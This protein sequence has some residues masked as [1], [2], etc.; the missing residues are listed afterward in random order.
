METNTLGRF[1]Y[2]HRK[3]KKK[4]KEKLLVGSVKT[5]IGHTESAAGVAGLIKVLLMMKHGKIVPSLHIKKDKSNLNPAIKLDV[6]GMDIPVDV[7]DWI[8]NEHGDRT[9]CVNSFGFGGSNGH[10]I[11]IQKKSRNACA[12]ETELRDNSSSE[13]FVTV[14]AA[15]PED[16][17]HALETFSAQLE[18]AEDSLESISYTSTCRRDHFPYRACF[19][20]ASL[21]SLATQISQRITQNKRPTVPTNI[22]FVYCGVGTTW[23]GMCS[24]LIAVDEAFRKGVQEVDKYLQPLA[25]MSMTKLFSDSTTD[26]SDPFLNHLAIFSTQVGLTEMWRN[27]RVEPGVIVGQS[28]GEVAAAYASG[29]FDLKTAVE[30]IYHRSKILANQIGGMM[31]VVKN[32]DVQ[33]LEKLCDSYDR[34]VTIAVYSSPV[35]CTLSG[36]RDVMD[37]I[38]CDVVKYCKE[39]KIDEF[40]RDL[41]VQCAYHC[42]MM[43]ACLPDIRQKL[44]SLRAAPRTFEIVSTVT[45][46]QAVSNEYQTG[47]YWAR[48]VRD[49]V[50]LNEAILASSKS[51][52]KNIFIEIGPK[53]ILRAHINDIL[54]Q[55]P[56]VCLPSM[57]YQ[58][59]IISR[60]STVIE[61]FE[62]GVNIEWNKEVQSSSL[63]NIPSY[64]FARR[65]ILFIPE[66]EKRKFQGLESTQ[67]TDHMF[68]RNSLKEGK[69]F[70]LTIGRNSTNFVYDH[71]MGGSL[72]VPGATYVEAALAIACRKLKLSVVKVAVSI[73]FLHTHTPTEEKE[74]EI[75]CGL[76]LHETSIDI[77]FTKGNRLLS[78]GRAFKSEPFHKKPLKIPKLIDIFSKENT[79][80]DVYAALERLGFKYGPSLCLIQRAWFS[81]TECLAEM[82]VPSSI[83]Q[84]FGKTHVHPAVIDA[85]FQVFGIFAQKTNTNGDP[86][87]PKGLHSLRV[88]GHL[89]P[90]LYCYT[91]K[92]RSVGKQTYYNAMLLDTDGCVICEVKDFYTQQL[93]SEP[94]SQSMC[95]SL[96]WIRLANDDVNTNSL[97]TSK[98]HLIVFATKEAKRFLQHALKEATINYVPLNLAKHFERLN[99]HQLLQLTEQ[100]TYD[101]VL[102]VPFTN[103]ALTQDTS[104]LLYVI[105]SRTILCLKDLILSLSRTSTQVPL[106]ILTNNT[107]MLSEQANTSPNLCGSELW[108]MVRCAALESLHPDI[109]L[110]DIDETN[111]DVKT[112]YKVINNGFQTEREIKIEGKSI[113]KTR[114]RHKLQPHRFGRKKVSHINDDE[115]AYL[116][117]TRAD[118]I[119]MPCM[120]IGEIN[121]SKESCS[122]TVSR[123][124]LQYA[125]LHNPSI[126]PTTN[127]DK[128]QKFLNWPDLSADGFNI[129]CLEGMGYTEDKNKSVNQITKGDAKYFCYPA[130]LATYVD[131]PSECVFSPSDIPCYCPGLLTTS[132][133]LFNVASL[134]PKRSSITVLVDDSMQF[135]Q[136]V[137]ENILKSV[138]G[139]SVCFIYRSDEL[140]DFFGREIS[141]SNSTQYLLGLTK[142]NS[143]IMKQMLNHVQ[144][145][146]CLIT[147]SIYLSSSMRQWI[148]H[149]HPRLPVSLLRCEDILQPEKMQH[150]LSALRGVL[151]K[152]SCKEI[153][154]QDYETITSKERNPLALPSRK[155]SLSDRLKLPKYIPVAHL[156]RKNCC[157]IVVGGLTGLGWEIMKM[158]AANG[159]G[160]LCSFSRRKPSAVQQNEIDNLMNTTK[161]S[162]K[163]LQV[164]ITDIH[165]LKTT[166]EKIQLELNGVNI[167]GIFNGAGVLSDSLLVNMSEE[168]LN[169]VLRPKVLG[170]LNLHLTTQHLQIDFFVMHSSIVSIIGN[171]GQCNYGA[172]NAF[173]D[174]LAHY[175]RSKRLS[176]QSINWGPLSVGM[177]QG[178]AEV[179]LRLQQIGMTMLQKEDICSLL[180]D[181]LLADNHQVTLGLFDWPQVGKHLMSA[182]LIDLIPQGTMAIQH[183]TQDQEQSQFDFESFHQLHDDEKDHVLFEHILKVLSKVVS[184][185][186]T[187]IVNPELKLGDLIIESFAAMSFVNNVFDLTGC[188]VPIQ[189]IL[190]DHATIHE[191][192][193][194]MR[195]NIKP[196][197]KDSASPSSIN[198]LDP[199]SKLS[200]TESAILLDYQKSGNKESF[201]RVIDV[202][203]ELTEVGLQTWE[204][205]IRHVIFMNPELRRKFVI[206][207]SG[208]AVNAVSEE[209]MALKIEAVSVD[210]MGNDDPRKQLSFDLQ[211]EL[212]IKFQ[213][214]FDNQRTVLRIILHVAVQ[215][216]RTQTLIYKDLNEVTNAVLNGQ[217]LP[218]KHKRPNIP[219]ILHN[220]VNKRKT[221][222][223]E[224]WA[225][226]M[227]GIKQVVSLNKT[228]LIGTLDANRFEVKTSRLPDEMTSRIL[229]FLQGQNFTVFQFFMSVYQLFLNGET[230]C[231]SVPVVSATD[232]RIHDEQLARA[233]GRC[234]NYTPFVANIRG[235]ITF[236]DFLVSNAKNVNAAIEHSL[237]PYHMILEEIPIPEIRP[238]IRRHLLVMDNMKDLSNLMQNDKSKIKLKNMWLTSNEDETSLRIFYDLNSNMIKL[239]F[240]YNKVVCAETVGQNMLAQIVSLI[241]QC[242]DNY[243]KPLTSLLANLSGLNSQTNQENESQNFSIVHSN[244]TDKRDSKLDNRKTSAS[245]LFKSS[246][247]PNDKF[248]HAGDNSVACKERGTE[249][250][251]NRDVLKSGKPQDSLLILQ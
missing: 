231:K 236:L 239:V 1:F 50:L 34:K 102:F 240:G 93:S 219:Q 119:Y 166:M 201:L 25:G 149:M 241:Q 114:L 56:A 204:K 170:S 64:V 16:L 26:Y 45:G 192:T 38:K 160:F 224:F 230:G 185:T 138:C 71:F 84:E 248:L 249:I 83:I 190:S 158:I 172:A 244:K 208:I 112:L 67:S 104:E 23:Q 62:N 133:I 148:N 101:A 96:E 100:R 54:K 134:V 182:K 183:Q 126:L 61:L 212:P 237:Y 159:G 242:L 167:K 5:N 92:V 177:A 19:V 200:F 57:S 79:Q 191:I 223:R 111:C 70:K 137:V 229:D 232:M 238:H 215:D 130:V 13:H 77:E 206:Q 125:C 42:H 193:V 247:H 65:K 203:I 29:S 95:F 147:L 179:E 14:T 251:S 118:E 72:L 152:F 89:Q 234:I 187:A 207:E 47:E 28:V 11:L 227:K 2:E 150:S 7:Q 173:I 108:G 198:F 97:T 157:Y 169:K 120:E 205:I 12:N 168:Q 48:N 94:E 68:L 144:N 22:V 82:H 194:F 88:K 121:A 98:P 81:N 51:N 162:I 225:S 80:E 181:T 6:Y 90:K 78:K 245:K 3:R 180:L 9:A 40:V 178:K 140:Q 110:V 216:L 66:G 145:L 69:E 139:C 35:A 122:A 31:M 156:F 55:I 195:E 189:M 32:V 87:F 171:T 75:D 103:M 151:Q 63:S 20:T 33:I 17:E 228:E 211:A 221:I 46:K 174:T 15:A 210:E 106:F 59:E 27:L 76:S 124:R 214:A 132:T 113:W 218:G 176:G 43:E 163:A 233:F 116:K 18:N 30:V 161:C 85:V 8:P 107:Q 117:T 21:N 196:I 129:M 209:E 217:K 123:L 142:I 222:L 146:K 135:T 10:A 153:V 128:K 49:P 197:Q 53:P 37:K 143:E 199:E 188:R 115:M 41:S 235:D 44:Q 58:K 184:I 246:V 24:Q 131:V 36:E 127:V 220:D 86:V 60:S 226:Q 91:V 213:I 165:S 186:D 141:M 74:D 99:E 243:D 155:L 73:E 154:N 202:A 105:S 136:E 52:H 250:N 39:N 4:H 109:R 175:R 164:D